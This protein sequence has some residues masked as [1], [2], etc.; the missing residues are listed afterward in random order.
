MQTV[1]QGWLLLKN[2]KAVALICLFLITIVGIVVHTQLWVFDTAEEDI[3]YVWLEGKRLLAGENPYARILLGN[4]RE[5]DKYAT[6]FPLFYWLS[7]LTQLLGFRD[8]STWLAFW[9][10]VFLMF[11]IGIAGL[12]FSRLNKN[13]LFTVGLF[14]ALFWLLNRWT[15]HVTQIA[16]IDFVPVF[17][18]LSSLITFKRY[19]Y[20]SLL[21]F[22]LSLAFKQ[23][24]VFLIPLYL[25]WVWQATEREKVKNVAIALLIIL[26]IPLIT[27]I[28][29]LLWNAEGFF[30]SILFSATRNP[31]GHFNVSSLDVF[32]GEIFPG[33]V[34]L[35]AK[36]PMLF[37]MGLVYLSA[38]RGKIGIY[39]SALLTLSVFVDFNSVLFRQYFVWTVPLLPLALCDFVSPTPLNKEINQ[40]KELELVR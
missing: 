32:I 39:M 8:Y 14:A 28:P 12:I 33:F 17:F 6:Y 31:G 40:T 18:L 38:L 13:N 27:S 1:N 22:S 10:P 37:L 9:R 11:N 20:T 3:Y 23:I 36:L 26:S 16:H 19:R 15:L 24:A 29:F 30:K 5:N 35:K 25:I 21:L 4:M 34:G 2:K 7:A